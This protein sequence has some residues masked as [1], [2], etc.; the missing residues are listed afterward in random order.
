MIVL[1]NGMAGWRVEF[2]TIAAVVA[3][4]V[5]A[6]GFEW[7]AVKPYGEFN[8][9]YYDELADAFLAAQT[10]FLRLPS[11]A[12]LALP[13]PYSAE[14]NESFR[15]RPEIPGERFSGVQ[16]LALYNGR[17]Y[18]QWGPVPALMLIPL[19]ALAGHDLPLGY[20]T[21]ILTTL[22][23]LA[24]LMSACLLARLCGLVLNPLTASLL[25]VGLLLCPF[26]TFNLGGIAVYQ[27]SVLTAQFFVALAFLSASSAF[28][29]RL[30]ERRE[31]PALLGLASLFVGLALGCHLE[32]AVLGV[33][34]PV[35]LLLW[36]RTDPRRPPLWR[37]A[38]P[39]AALA[40]PAGAFVA[41]ILIYN[42]VRFGD[43]LEIG[44]SWQL[45]AFVDIPIRLKQV[46]QLLREGGGHGRRRP[47]WRRL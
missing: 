40:L 3:A 37:M 44:M 17:L 23:E 6:L 34:L 20:G 22:A 30:I 15:L 46:V 26:W 8:A 32:L 33:M 24:Y 11:P 14:D 47:A 29:S 28:Y 2:L 5:L 35:I 12:L 27:I 13:D 10:S 19:R 42:Y 38:G 16:D 36:W 45:S 18:A 41:G 7:S 43:I 9:T 39:A 31:Y 1:K 4:I 21:L 25:A